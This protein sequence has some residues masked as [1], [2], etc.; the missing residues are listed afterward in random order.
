MGMTLGCRRLAFFL[1]LLKVV[2][3]FQILS[4]GSTEAAKEHLVIG[5]LA[6]ENKELVSDRWQ[7]LA[8]YLNEAV[9][10][11]RFSIVV[12]DYEETDEA[13][14]QGSIDFVFTNPGHFVALRSSNNLSGAIVTLMES[15]SGEP[16]ESFGGVIFV[17]S[18][19]S[20]IRSP[21][22]LRGKRIAAVGLDSLGGFQAQAYELSLMGVDI[23]RQSTIVLT[24]MPHSLVVSQVLQGKAD[25]G[26][27]RT[28]VLER[29]ISRGELGTDDVRIINPQAVPGFGQH[30]STKLY[31]EWPLAVLSHVET[32]VARDVAAALLLLRPETSH[33]SALGIYGFNIP[34]SYMLVE[35]MMRSLRLYPFDGDASFNLREI[36]ERYYLGI[37][38]L[39]LVLFGACITAIQR[40]YAGSIVKKH[41]RELQSVMERLRVAYQ[42]LEDISLKDEMTGMFNRRYFETVFPS[43]VDAAMSI[44]AGACL[45]VIDI[46]SF[47]SINDRLGHAAGDEAIALVARGIKRALLRPGDFVARYGGDEFVVVLGHTTEEGARKVAKRIVRQVASE[48]MPP[49]LSG[50]RSLSLSVGGVIFGPSTVLQVQ[51]LVRLADEYMYDV[52]RAGGNAIRIVALPAEPNQPDQ[53]QI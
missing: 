35:D 51:E 41:N 49:R 26:F 46:D 27:V 3:L 45:M 53:H 32:N 28:G 23:A 29:M 52:K 1:L 14:A 19:N 13:V 11:Y 20:S 4:V 44:N 9:L 17:A 36:W 30:L 31:P 37:S 33:T 39:L 7:P 48:P 40:T 18:D 24:G 6:F 21:R 38:A 8:D 34:S 22:D 2:M 16:Y 10:D 50:I 25:V 15:V 12:L 42:E 5:I 43:R 47:K